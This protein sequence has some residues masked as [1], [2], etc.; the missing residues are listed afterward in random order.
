MLDRNHTLAGFKPP[1]HI[2]MHYRQREERDEPLEVAVAIGA[3]ETVVMAAFTGVPERVDKYGIAGGLRGEPLELVKCQTVDLCV[4]ASAEIVLEGRVLPHIRKPEGPFG[5]HT[6]YHGGGVRMPPV[7][8]VTAITHRNDPILRGVLLG[9]PVD[10]GHMAESVARSASAISIFRLAGPP[11]VKAVFC[12]PEA[13]PDLMVVIQM[14]PQYVGHSRE[15][16]HFWSSIGRA[17]NM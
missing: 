7:F 9:K 13:D 17:A 11:G 10:E 4:P 5:E 2:A 14:K 16:G 15:V 12:P 3:E 8:E 1:T 6:G